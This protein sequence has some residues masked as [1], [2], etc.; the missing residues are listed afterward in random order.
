[1]TEIY[2]PM[3]LKDREPYHYFEGSVRFCYAQGIGTCELYCW[4]DNAPYW[5]TIVTVVE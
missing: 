4:T 2:I 5:N 3:D 1:M